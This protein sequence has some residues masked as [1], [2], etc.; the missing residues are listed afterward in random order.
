M[1]NDPISTALPIMQRPDPSDTRLLRDAFSRFATGVTVITAC[2]AQGPVAITAN[3]F[4]SVSLEPPLVLWCLG[5][6][7]N[8]YDV[9]ISAQ[10]Y[11]IHVLADTQQDLCD[12]FARDGDALA[13]MPHG[14][15]A[16]GVPVLPNCLARFDCVQTAVHRAGDHDVIIGEVMAVGHAHGAALGF[17]QSALGPI[18]APTVT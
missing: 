15:N 4:T 18:A 3:S 14:I 6:S 9:F 8:R 13:Q 5:L 2:S 10:D 11:A 17:F 16:A 7:S 12:A 1:K